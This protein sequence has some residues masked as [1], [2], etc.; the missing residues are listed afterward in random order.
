MPGHAPA[1]AILPDH[2]KE[3]RDDQHR[4]PSA[5]LAFLE[6]ECQGRNRGMRY[7]TARYVS[8]TTSH[9]PPGGEPLP[10]HNRQ[11]RRPSRVAATPL[12]L[13]KRRVDPSGGA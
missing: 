3:A 2:A 11:T 10:R 7:T 8:A 1:V 9:D 5:Y 13:A 12:D 4:R 6:R